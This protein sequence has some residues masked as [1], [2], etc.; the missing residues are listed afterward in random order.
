MEVVCGCVWVW[1][2]SSVD[3][4]TMSVLW[5]SWVLFVVYF[6][7]AAA[8]VCYRVESSDRGSKTI[9]KEFCGLEDVINCEVPD[10]IAPLAVVMDYKARRVLA[11]CILPI[12][13]TTMKFGPASATQS[14]DVSTPQVKG[15]VTLLEAVA[16]RLNVKAH[17][18]DGRGVVLAVTTQAHIGFDMRSCKEGWARVTIVPTLCAHGK[19]E[20]ACNDEPSRVGLPALPLLTCTLS[21]SWVYPTRHQ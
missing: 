7:V 17:T 13:G 5:Q 11:T 16:K 18:V 2:W 21:P 9:G 4:S 6:C 10:L 12:D 15:L 3:A 8:G 14:V 19:R 1:V 20:A